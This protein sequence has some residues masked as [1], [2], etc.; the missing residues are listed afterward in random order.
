V[1]KEGKQSILRHNIKQSQSMKVSATKPM[2][3]LIQEWLNWN[4]G[5][6]HFDCK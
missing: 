4:D 5:Y 6:R 2:R 3:N 1:Q